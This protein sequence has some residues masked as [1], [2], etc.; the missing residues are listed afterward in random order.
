MQDIDERI[1]RWEK[2]RIEQFGYVNNL[3]FGTTIVV[4]GFLMNSMKGLVSNTP[5]NIQNGIFLMFLSVSFGCVC[6]VSRL[7]DFRNTVKSARAEKEGNEKDRQDS[8]EKANRYGKYSWCLLY[9]QILFFILGFFVALFP[10]LVFD[11]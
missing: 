8:K 5:N 11:K 3:L 7:L 6:A 1:I 10:F 9:A 2:I 4:V